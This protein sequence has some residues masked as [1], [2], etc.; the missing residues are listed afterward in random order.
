MQIHD[1]ADLLPALAVVSSVGQGS[2]ETEPFLAENVPVLH[3]SQA[4][5][6]DAAVAA[7]NLPLAHRIQ[8]SPDVA[9]V[10]LENV[11]PSQLVQAAAPMLSL[12][13][14]AAQGAHLPARLRP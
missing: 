3:S 4:D 12:N 14:P 7:E 2:H 9:A 6:E 11:P 13:V 5:G 10:L 8:V 1:A